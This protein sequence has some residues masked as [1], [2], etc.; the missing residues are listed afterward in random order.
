MHGG[1]TD[2]AAGNDIA[3]DRNTFRPL[4]FFNIGIGHLKQIAVHRKC[5]E[6][7]GFCRAIGSIGI[8]RCLVQRCLVQ[9]V[10]SDLQNAVGQFD[11]LHFRKQFAATKCTLSEVFQTG[12]YFDIGQ[13]FAEGERAGSERDD[14]A[15][16]DCASHPARG[17]GAASDLRDCR[18][19]GNG[20]KRATDPKGVCT[21]DLQ[22]FVQRHA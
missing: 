3:D 13:V 14:V 9:R 16:D 21:D 8:D 18:G 12:R 15:G 17:E 6:R 1:Q 10:P 7:L 19:N 4:V 20:G 2:G 22:T 11:L 5:E